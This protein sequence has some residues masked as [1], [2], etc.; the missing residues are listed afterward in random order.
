MR[1]LR[2]SRKECDAFLMSIMNTHGNE[3]L[4]KFF[5]KHSFVPVHDVRMCVKKLEKLVRDGDGS[6]Q[7]VLKKSVRQWIK[8]WVKV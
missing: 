1:T 2:Q 6:P 4:R 8:D 7:T 3:V 5:S